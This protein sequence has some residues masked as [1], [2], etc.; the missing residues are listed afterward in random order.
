MDATYAEKIKQLHKTLAIPADYAAQRKLTLQYE[1]AELIAIENDIFARQQQLT[2]EAALHWNKMREAAK[3]EN[4]LLNVVSAFRSVDYQTQLFQKKLAAGQSIEKILP[5]NAAPGY[6][7]HHTG[8][9]LDLTTPDCTPLEEIFETTSAFAWL[10]EHAGGFGF[11]LS[12]P[13][14]NPHDFVYEPWHWI[15]NTF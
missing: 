14:N 5:V 8:R 3:Q 10:I 11:K 4:I 9:C 1:P 13:R 6:S 15:F 2:P 12:Y 7:E